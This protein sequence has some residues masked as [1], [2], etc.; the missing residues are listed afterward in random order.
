MAGV[1]YLSGSHTGGNSGKVTAALSSYPL[2]LSDL[3]TGTV[4]LS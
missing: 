2:R 1:F 4:T 3:L